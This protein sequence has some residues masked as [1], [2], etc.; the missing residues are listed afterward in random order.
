APWYGSPAPNNVRDP[1]DLQEGYVQLFPKHTTGFGL[2]AG[3]VMLNYGEGRLIGSPQ[4]AN[5]ARTYDHAH[6]S[7][8]TAR[9]QGEALLASPVRVRTDDFNWPVL[10]ERVWGVYSTVPEIRKNASFDLYVLRHDQNR[11][12]GF[13]GGSKTAG[14]DLLRVNMLGFRLTGSLTHGWKYDLEGVAQNGKVGSGTH[15][16]GG[17]YSGV[18][19]RWMA[20]GRPLDVSG[21]Y[22]FASGSGDP[23]DASRSR[24]F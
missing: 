14:T 1:A 11:P 13:T 12:G 5:T 21:E 22:K 4:W 15:R 8:A 10:G 2:M 20:A 3:R 24:T 17:W 16:A 9:V 19:R 23:G 18:S 6:G 7:F